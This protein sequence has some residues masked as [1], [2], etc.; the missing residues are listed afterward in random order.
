MTV[1]LTLT[2]QQIKE[3]ADQLDSGMRCF[4]HKETSE[5]LFVP[6]IEN[7][8]DIDEELFEEELEELDN[9]FGDYVEIEKPASRD[10]FEV[11]ADFAEQ[12]SD[13]VKLK[14][15]LL[16]AL[17][18]KHPFREFKFIVDNSGVYRQ[19]WFDFKD[20]QLKQWIMDKFEQATGDDRED[21]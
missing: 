16:Q 17:D 15:Q 1:M 9:N 10:S 12:L 4:L 3:I 8:P 14:T 7:N 11:M 18:K 13:N 6:D 20:R 2:Q 5:L 19:Q 21:D